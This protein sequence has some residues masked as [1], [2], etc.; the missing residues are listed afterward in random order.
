MA[1]SQ[2]K[3]NVPQRQPP[4]YGGMVERVGKLLQ[5]EVRQGVDALAMDGGVLRQSPVRRH[6]QGSHPNRDTQMKQELERHIAH[7]IG[8]KP[9]GFIYAPTKRMKT[10]TCSLSPG[11]FMAARNDLDTFPSRSA[12]VEL[13]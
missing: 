6:G 2:K 4:S 7:S 11:L 10:L 9:R 8:A 3:P 13:G 5:E 12:S 1:A